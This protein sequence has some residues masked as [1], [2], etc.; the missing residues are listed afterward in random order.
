M[1][2]GF[3]IKLYEPGQ[4]ESLYTFH[5]ED[6]DLNELDRLLG[7]EEVQSNPDFNRF[8]QRLL[9]GV[10]KHH[11]FRRH[12]FKDE[13][14]VQALF[15]PYPKEE[16]E[17]LD[18]PYPPQLRLYCVRRRGIVLAGHGGVKTTRTFQE[19]ERLNQAVNELE[20]VDDRLQK[21]LDVRAVRFEDKGRRLAGTLEFEQKDPRL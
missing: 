15:A 17:A 19:D 2:F 4:E 8:E 1:N 21:C 20:Y 10:D 5:H 14:K 11:G 9:D 16:K 3:E 18:T 12:W 7:D 6:R 13:R